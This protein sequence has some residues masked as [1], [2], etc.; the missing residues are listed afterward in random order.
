[1][2]VKEKVHLEEVQKV[3]TDFQTQV[4]EQLQTLYDNVGKQLKETKMKQD[5]DQT[6]ESAEEV[7]EMVEKL[8]HEDSKFR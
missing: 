2:Q 4:S 8:R 3:L 7:R 1:M 6:R 5:L